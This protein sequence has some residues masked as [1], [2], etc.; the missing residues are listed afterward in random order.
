MICKS[1]L[2][3]IKQKKLPPNIGLFKNKLFF[4]QKLFFSENEFLKGLVVVV[5]ENG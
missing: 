3:R 2:L 5:V 4:I 1:S